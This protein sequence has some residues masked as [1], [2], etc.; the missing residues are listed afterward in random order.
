MD[1]LL[2]DPLPPVRLEDQVQWN[3]LEL[4][5]V[6][7][8]TFMWEIVYQSTHRILNSSF[9]REKTFNENVRRLG[10]SYASAFLASS[11]LLTL[12]VNSLVWFWN[13]PEERRYIMAQQH[14]D[15]WFDDTQ[16]ARYSAYAFVGWL[17]CDLI[18]ILL[19][20]GPNKLG[21]WDIVVHHVL[22]ITL[23]SSCI[24]YGICLFSA[25][26]LL[27]GELSTLPLNVR[28]FIINTGNSDTAA[29]T[30]A[31][32]LFAVSFFL[33][34]VA[35]YWYGLF[36]YLLYGPRQLLAHGTPEPL[37]AG[38]T[39]LLVLG[40]VLNVFWFKQIVDVAMDS[41]S[42]KSTNEPEKSESQK[43]MSVVG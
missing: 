11:V 42:G 25:G 26:W 39:F 16:S 17:L 18:H 38:V 41:K 13:A 14:N 1:W 34:R 8:W 28:F 36:D 10:C 37:V 9:F 19:N 15:P 29:M 43:V 4:H 6:V 31:N 7:K 23:A 32:G 33:T 3:S 20:F 5:E 40:A 35:L 2:H 22:F 12:G 27:C 30:L 21:G 24:G